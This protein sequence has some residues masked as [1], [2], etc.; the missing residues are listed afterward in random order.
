MLDNKTILNRFKNIEI[1]S[2]CSNY[3]GMKLEIN[4]KKKM[5][6]KTQI[7][8]LSNVLLNNQEIIKG[9]KGKIRNLETK[10]TYQ[11]IKISGIQQKEFSEEGSKQNFLQKTRKIPSKHSKF[12]PKGARKGKENE[13]NK[14][15]SGSK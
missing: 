14:D 2:I 12:T 13:G 7:W 3:N 6:K 10:E 1:S 4:H 8:R 11:H 15:Q 5:E 9:I